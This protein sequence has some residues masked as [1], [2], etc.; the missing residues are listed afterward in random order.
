MCRW[1]APDRRA[2]TRDVGQ[3]VFAPNGEVP[4]RGV[5]ASSS[6]ARYPRDDGGASPTTPLQPTARDLIVQT[7]PPAVAADL[8]VRHH[9]LH[10]A[11]AGV[12]L[13]L[14]IFGDDLL[15]GAVA[16]NAGPINGWR[17]VKGARREGCLCL[18]R[19]W[20][21]DTLP[22]NSESRV[23]DTRWRPETVASVA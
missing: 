12:K 18:A 9:Y 16:F 3:R 14:G 23:S 8:F 19:L 15:A 1:Q 7:I 13:T 21:T 10:S 2:T 20:L 5:G 4:V 17:L 6:T 11:P 22:R